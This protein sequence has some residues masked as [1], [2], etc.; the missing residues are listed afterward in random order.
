MNFQ[1]ETSYPAL[2]FDALDTSGDEFHVAVLRMTLAV[3]PD[4]SLTPVTDQPDLVMVDEF[5]GERFHSSVKQ[6]SDLA[7][8]K[9][10]CDVIVIGDALA[11]G[12][13]PMK[14][15]ETGI[16]ITRRGES[17]LNKSLW[18][19][20]PRYWLKRFGR[21]WTLTDP[22]PI[23]RL[24]MRYEYAYGGE[25]R[26]EC[27][28]RAATQIKKKYR[29]TELQR[30]QH[31]AGFEKAPVAHSCC[32]ANP[33]GIGFA[34]SWYLGAKKLTR[35]PAPQIESPIDPIRRL[36]TP[37]L[38]QGLGAIGRPWEPRSNQCGTIDAAFVKSERWLPDDFDFAYWNGAHPDLQVP[39]LKGDETV[40]LINIDV[41]NLKA[42]RLDSMGNRIRRMA[43]PSYRFYAVVYLEEG[44]IINRELN[45]DTCIIDS[46]VGRVSLVYRVKL[47][48]WPVIDR[49]E[50]VQLS[51]VQ[52]AILDQH[53]D[54]VATDLK[55]KKEAIHG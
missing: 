38:P 24:P 31:P 3:S 49:V 20:G 46:P 48:V 9:P 33:I 43:L 21:G 29:L 16:R 23:A 34:E 22:E 10:W 4:G 44:G 28:D 8:Y 41:K 2:A 52:K 47:P 5:L 39:W 42:D 12:R 55:P 45:I 53:C 6:E 18:V 36:G 15:F 7:P 19:T 35:V 26:I 32:A 27:A 50:V 54:A 51:E 14:R 40:D 1:N 30:R 11:P 17:V 37:Y 13:Q 25:C